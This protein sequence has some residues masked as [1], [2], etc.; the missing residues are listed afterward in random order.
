MDREQ[1][2]V[3]IAEMKG[4]LDR[5]IVIMKNNWENKIS[6]AVQTSASLNQEE[7]R[8]FLKGYNQNLLIWNLVS[9]YIEA[10][11]LPDG[12]LPFLNF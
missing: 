7:Q 9:H 2:S 8:G 12:S 4:F 11:K 6:T 1:N 5:N 3:K 10:Q